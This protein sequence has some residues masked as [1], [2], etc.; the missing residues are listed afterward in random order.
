[1]DI[2][3]VFFSVFLTLGD[4]HLLRCIVTHQTATLQRPLEIGQF[5][6]YMLTQQ[7]D[8]NATALAAEFAFSES[9]CICISH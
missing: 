8:G 4:R 5:T 9:S 6:R 7:G 3:S 2:G 1:M